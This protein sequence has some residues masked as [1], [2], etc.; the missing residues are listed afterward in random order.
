MGFGLVL[1]LCD[2]RSLLA[3]S[4]LISSLAIA[5]PSMAVKPKIMYVTNMIHFLKVVGSTNR[6]VQQTPDN[7][8]T[9]TYHIRVRLL[10]FSLF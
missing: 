9:Q 10:S 7:K 6:F 5:I 2:K 8:I 4:A 1:D 3:Y